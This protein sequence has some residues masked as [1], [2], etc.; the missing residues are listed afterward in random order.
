ML[1]V[2]EKDI[3]SIQVLLNLKFYAGVLVHL[4]TIK[5]YFQN[6]FKILDF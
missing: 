4:N 6:R 3:S 5:H 2:I 1:R